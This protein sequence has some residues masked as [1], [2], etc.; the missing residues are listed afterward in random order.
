MACVVVLSI[1]QSSNMLVLAII[2][3]TTSADMFDVLKH[4]LYNKKLVLL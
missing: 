2:N 1:L 3:K 4:T